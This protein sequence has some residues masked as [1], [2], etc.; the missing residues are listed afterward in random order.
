MV[1][2][3]PR[4]LEEAGV[5]NSLAKAL[6]F[7]H[8]DVERKFTGDLVPPDTTPVPPSHDELAFAGC[9]IRVQ[10]EKGELPKQAISGHVFQTNRTCSYHVFVR[11][12]I[13]HTL[14][15]FRRP[16]V[17]HGQNDVWR[18]IQDVSPELTL[19]LPSTHGVFTIAPG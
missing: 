9:P 16:V 5:P 15:R 17:H 2:S 6:L 10:G 14:V 3:N 7:L 13:V 11:Q 1:E 4:K 12:F 18:T 19:S 8:S